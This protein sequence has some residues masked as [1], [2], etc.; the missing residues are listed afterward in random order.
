[1]SIYQTD[2]TL[3]QEYLYRLI[4]R[5]SA[6]SPVSWLDQTLHQVRTAQSSQSLYMAFGMAAR[7]MDKNPLTLSTAE[8]EQAE[9]LRRGFRPQWTV[10]RATRVLLL[11][12]Y[13]HGDAAA[14]QQTLNTLFNAADVNE[15]EALYASL[16]LL[17]YPEALRGRCAE[18][19]RTNMRNVLEAIVLDNPYPAD[20]LDEE[21]WNQMVLKAIFNGLPLIRIYDFEKRRNPDLARMISDFAHERWAAGRTLSPEVWRAVAP[22]LNDTNVRD[23]QLLFGQSSQPQHEAAALACAE[24]DLPAAKTLLAAHPAL[25][26]RI[27]NGEL[28]WETVAEQL[29]VNSE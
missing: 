17:P 16:P 13:P 9:A 19:I 3:S 28:N 24:S 10:L 22:F 29:S 14:Y 6:A 18:G 4:V 5:Q 7:R 11:L 20:Y 21:A 27:T 25:H 1:M 2:L 12:A 23:I 26:N 8:L 15:L